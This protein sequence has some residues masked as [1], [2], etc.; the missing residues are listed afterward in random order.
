LFLDNFRLRFLLFS[1][2]I[3][4]YIIGLFIPIIDIDAAQY[5]NISREMSEN[6]SFIQVL[7]NGGAYLDKPPLLFWCSAISLKLFGINEFAYKLPS[8]L[9]SLL[10]IWA[11]YKLGK[12]VS[13][14]NTGIFSAFIAASCQAWF[15]MNNDVKTD[16]ILTAC[17]CLSLYQLAK[18]I[19]EYKVINAIYAGLFIGLSMLAKGPIG[20]IVPAAGAFMFLV[21]TKSYKQ[22]FNPKGLII[23]I[24]IALVISPFCYGLYLQWDL[25][26]ELDYFGSKNISGVKFFLWDQ[27][28]GRI[29][30]NNIWKNDAGPFFLA[31]NTIWALLP[32]TLIFVTALISKILEIGRR[33]PDYNNNRLDVFVFF[34]FLLP[35][36]A[37]STSKYQLPHYAYVTYPC[38]AVITGEFIA[39]YWDDVNYSIWKS[40]LKGFQ[41]LLI[42][43]IPLFSFFLLGFVFQIYNPIA[44]VL[45]GIIS[46]ILLIILLRKNAPHKLIS[47]SILAMIGFNLTM[48]I[49]IYPTLLK[50]QST[51]QIGAYIH[52]HLNNKE[53]YAFRGQCLQSTNV[54]AQKY[55][56]Y[57]DPNT[58]TFN[59][60]NIYLTCDEAGFKEILDIKKKVLIVLKKKYFPI[61]RL[62]AQFLNPLTRSEALQNIYLIKI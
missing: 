34:S 14:P 48:N 30:G 44:Y 22:I 26:P 47:G 27:S 23:L 37:L 32:F 24:I 59:Q 52:N 60:G 51:N 12:L 40:F 31:S 28:F 50:Y 3:L 36:I 42:I 58:T 10:G 18:Y 11:I 21:F 39:K 41:W 6:N 54:Y 61:Q 33:R 5:A 45:L 15:L 46:F 9:F 38:A 2:I 53:V 43:I 8:F 4:V 20:L 62:N 13:G 7:N 35:F 29:T 16:T 55:L 17:I 49:F 25:H 1:L 57:L 19:T 56:P